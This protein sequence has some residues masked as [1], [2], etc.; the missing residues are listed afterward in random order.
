MR[1]F[2]LVTRY[3]VQSQ[4]YTADTAIAAAKEYVALANGPRHWV[5]VR[6]PQG[7]IIF[8]GSS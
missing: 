4:H 6:S 8:E 1:T 3:G 5:K 2:I 7:D